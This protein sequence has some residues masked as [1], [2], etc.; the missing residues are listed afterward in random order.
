MALML[1]RMAALLLSASAAGCCIIEGSDRTMMAV[2]LIAVQPLVLP[3]FAIV[4]QH[5]VVYAVVRL[6]DRQ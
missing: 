4:E 3:A 5:P 1:L 2:G 6:A